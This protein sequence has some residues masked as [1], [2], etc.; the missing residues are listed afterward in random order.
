[1]TYAHG[2]LQRFVKVPLQYVGYGDERIAFRGQEN[3]SVVARGLWFVCTLTQHD[4]T[5]Q[6]DREANPQH[7]DGRH[8][9]THTHTQKYKDTTKSLS[10]R[11]FQRPR[12]TKLCG[13]SQTVLYFLAIISKCKFIS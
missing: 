9:H 8:T 5:S 7:S 4:K 1:M 13:I 3:I 12:T 2:L 6:T 10:F 11:H